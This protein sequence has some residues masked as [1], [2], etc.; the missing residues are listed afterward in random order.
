MTE[1]KS[2]NVGQQS[3]LG[4]LPATVI[5]NIIENRLD[6]GSRDS[7][8]KN[9]MPQHYMMKTVALFADISGFTKLGEAYAKKGR[10]GPEFL[11]FSLNRYMDE[12]INIIGKSGGDIFKFAGD[13][14]LVIWPE[15]KKGTINLT[16]ACQRAIQC[17]LEIQSK[18]HNVELAGGQKLSIKV[19][20]GV[21]ECTILVVGGQF[22]RCEYLS[23]G[24]ALAQSCICETKALGGGETI[25]H[26]NVKNL[27]PNV[28]EYEL[29][30]GVDAYGNPYDDAEGRFYRIKRQLGERIATKADTYLMRSQFS[31][32][33][34]I[35]KSH[36]LKSFV[37]AAITNYLD[38]EK[39][40]WSREIRL[41]SIMFFKLSISLEDTRTTEGVQLIQKITNCVQRC[42][43]RTRGALNKFLM[44][45]KG[46]LMLICWGL[47]PMSANDDHVKAV[48]TGLSLMEHLKEYNCGALMGITTGTCFTGVVGASGGRREY[49]L[50]GGVVNLSARF[51][52]KSCEKAKEHKFKY[53][54]LLDETTKDVSLLL[55]LFNKI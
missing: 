28:F 27:V 10:I 31:S 55:L 21:G 43:Y 29:C 11:A 53:L 16:E 32:E 9:S 15:L 24:E 1:N 5:Q 35:Q 12:L 33:K 30:T 23:V 49:S 22:R 36:L 37:P 47:P 48:Y 25:C 45:E 39:E 42:I 14:L 34:I 50:L 3:L 17:G 13:A 6:F 4:Y 2:L 20:I 18:L 38:I 41:V 44:D 51:M 40:S 52:Q 26:E 7:D 46:S 8:W 19:G 54:C